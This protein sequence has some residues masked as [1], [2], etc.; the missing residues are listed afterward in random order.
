MER[1]SRLREA[2]AV[3]NTDQQVRPPSAWLSLLIP[4]PLRQVVEL[5]NRAVNKALA[6]S[7]DD[8]DHERQYG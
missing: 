8:E 2:V 7:K 6:A 5:V 1:V 3:I 4:C